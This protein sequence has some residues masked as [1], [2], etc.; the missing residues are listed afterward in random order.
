MR[1]G[2]RKVSIRFKAL[3]PSRVVQVELVFMRKRRNTV[4]RKKK[5]YGYTEITEFL[6][7]R[8][9]LRHQRVAAAAGR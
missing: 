8:N 1:N 6:S 7:Q 4:S 3:L 5:G 2:S 9:G